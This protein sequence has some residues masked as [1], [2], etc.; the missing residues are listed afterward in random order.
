MNPRL[1]AARAIQQVGL[2]GRSLSQVLPDFLPRVAGSERALVQELVYGTLRWKQ[3]LDCL[4]AGLLDKPLKAKDRDIEDLLLTGLYQLA[5]MRIKPH[6]AV[7]ET[8]QA[9]KLAGKPWAV[10]LVNAVLRNFQRRRQALEDQADQ[11]P[12]SRWSHPAWLIER[13][14]QDWPGRWQSILEANNRRAPMT[15]RNNRLCQSREQY[16]HKLAAAGIEGRPLPWS[17]DAIQLQQPVEVDRLPGFAAGEVSVQDGAAQ[18]AAGLLAPEPGMRVLDACA[19]PGGKTAHLLEMQ[20]DVA[21]LQALDMDPGRLA[22][23]RENLTRLGLEAELIQGDASHPQDWWDGRQYQRILL[24]VPCSASGVIRRHPDIKLLR[25]AADIERLVQRQAAILE[26]IWPLLASGGRLLYATC[27]V[28]ADENHRQVA[29]FLQR[30]ADATALDLEYD[31]GLAVSP[32][33]QLF[34]A[35]HGEVDMDGFY[36]ALLSKT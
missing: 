25:Q 7:N 33:R 11:D 1:A 8:V 16:L 5:Y 27:S 36:Y 24:D 2:H 12:V 30:H 17:G 15:L 9:A 29:V 10:R 22:L 6:A 35:Q 20:P 31:W 26:A 18:L 4:L 34:P 14:R 28:L 32:G 21:S 19:A 13:I 23:V 3:R